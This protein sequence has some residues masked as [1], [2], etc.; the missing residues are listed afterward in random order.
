MS[1]RDY[2][3]VACIGFIFLLSITWLFIYYIEYGYG[4]DTVV[5]LVPILLGGLGII[6]GIFAIV[7]GKD[8]VDV[9]NCEEDFSGFIDNIE[10]KDVC[11]IPIKKN[12]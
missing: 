6:A 8:K 9:H 12:K 11:I 5:Y 1:E 4:A 10:N 7:K 2:G 3:S